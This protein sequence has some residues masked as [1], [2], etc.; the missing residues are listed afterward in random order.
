MALAGRHKDKRELEALLKDMSINNKLAELRRQIEMRTIGCGWAQFMTKWTF[1]ADE[2]AH[3]L[4]LLQRMLLDDVLPHEMALRRQKRLPTEAAPPQLTTRVV[5][6]LGTDDADAL[7]LK[8][9]GLFNTSNLLAKAQ[10]A[11]EAREAA[12]ISDSVEAVQ[13]L[14][15][16][17]FDSK[18]MGRRL[19]IC[20]PYKDKD[21]QTIKI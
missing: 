11:R 7:R 14:T 15:P 16:P 21:G 13:P 1:F 20:W 8:A 5:K 18:L 6:T 2:R 3:T 17:A 9:K 10:V 4:E 12:G 19:E